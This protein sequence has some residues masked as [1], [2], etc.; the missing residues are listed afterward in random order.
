MVKFDLPRSRG[1]QHLGSTVRSTRLGAAPTTTNRSKHLE[2]G[3]TRRNGDE[4]KSGPLTHM[5]CEACAIG[6]RSR[7][8]LLA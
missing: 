3:E 6:G 5:E 8:R 2:P 1:R 7:T 4:G